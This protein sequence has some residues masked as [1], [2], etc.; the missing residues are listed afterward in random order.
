[1][2]TELRL[3]ENSLALKYLVVET[4]WAI[5]AP[6][7]PNPN[8]FRP[9]YWGLWEIRTSQD[10]NQIDLG[11]LNLHGKSSSC[12]RGKFVIAPNISAPFTVTHSQA[13]DLI[14]NFDGAELDFLDSSVTE[15]IG[16]FRVIEEE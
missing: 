10:E 8:F 16:I 15:P 7:P 6:F 9:Q 12:F 13:V 11:C 5:L 1:M 14:E 2:L 4:K 3:N